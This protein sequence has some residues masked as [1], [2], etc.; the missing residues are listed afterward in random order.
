MAC[1]LTQGFLAGCKDSVGGVKEFYISVRP[2]DFVATKN[3]SGMVASYTGSCT[4]YKYV[5]RKQ[6]STFGETIA[7][8]EENGNVTVTQTAQII[9]SKM[10]VTKQNEILLLAQATLLIIAKDQAGVFWL[11]GSAN[12]ADMVTDATTA[13][14][15]Y[16]DLNGYTIDF[17]AMEQL[18]MPPIYSAAFSASI[19]P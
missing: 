18:P 17:Q 5:P 2:T 14:K 10:E 3:A 15:A 11:I 12:G 13:G 4:W 6:T 19:A 9:L 7:V 8:S 16:S 1:A